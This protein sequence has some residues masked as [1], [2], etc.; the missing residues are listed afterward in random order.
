MADTCTY[1][2]DPPGP[3][4]RYPAGGYICRHCWYSGR[5]LHD[6]LAGVI[7][8]LNAVT[9]LEWFAEHTGGGCAALIARRGIQ[10]IWLTAWPDVLALNSTLADVEQ[11]GWMMG[12]YPD[13]DD[14]ETFRMWPD[15]DAPHGLHT[16]QVPMIARQALAWLNEQENT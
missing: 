4:D 7:H 15:L 1:C 8:T 9:G 6:N 2:G 12:A 13:H 14:C 3:G 10:S 16:E 5:V 11:S